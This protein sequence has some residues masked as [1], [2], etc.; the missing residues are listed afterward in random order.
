MVKDNYEPILDDLQNLL[1]FISNRSSVEIKYL[2]VLCM[3]ILLYK[4][5]NMIQGD[6]Y[7]NIECWSAVVA[8]MLY[9]PNALV[10]LEFSNCVGAFVKT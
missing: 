10:K 3:K 7:H 1:K 2:G 9:E 5:G 8:S 6:F 4:F